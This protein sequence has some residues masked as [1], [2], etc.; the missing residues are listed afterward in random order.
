MMRAIEMTNEIKLL[1]AFIEAS[2]FD[3]IE[4]N[5]IYI[6]GIK[7]D[8]LH[9]IIPCDNPDDVR[10]ESYYK[11]TKKPDKDIE[12][13]F[14][15]VFKKQVT[16]DDDYEDLKRLNNIAKTFNINLGDVIEAYNE[17]V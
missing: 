16:N 9:S 8:D 1:R 5:D 13:F 3:V 15:A 2:G 7:Q 11:V 10:Y 17:N 12:S 6:K 14:G 4:G